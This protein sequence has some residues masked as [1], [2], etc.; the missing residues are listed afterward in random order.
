MTQS[1]VCRYPERALQCAIDVDHPPRLD[2]ISV[3]PRRGTTAR[4][5]STQ[6]HLG[7]STTQVVSASPRWVPTLKHAI[8]GQLVTKVF[9]VD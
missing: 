6:I 7:V 4:G 2:S 8:Q 9:T 5:S 3:Y 1:P